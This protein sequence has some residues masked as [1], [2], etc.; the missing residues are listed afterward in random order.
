MFDCEPSF[1]G[2]LSNYGFGA[3]LLILKKDNAE[4]MNV[5]FHKKTM[6]AVTETFVI[7]LDLRIPFDIRIIV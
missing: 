2:L 6:H 1:G 3:F 5:L 4:S 7:L